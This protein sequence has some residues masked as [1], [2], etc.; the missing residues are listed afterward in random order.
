MNR[1]EF[2]SALVLAPSLLQAPMIAAQ[3][4]EFRP[5]RRWE[6]WED[7]EGSFFFVRVSWA[8]DV[9]NGNILLSNYEKYADRTKIIWVTIR[10]PKTSRIIQ[11]WRYGFEKEKLAKLGRISHC[12]SEQTI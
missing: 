12:S 9:N 6:H 1:R 5:Y 11:E 3:P 7:F 4:L 8:P 2:L 10:E